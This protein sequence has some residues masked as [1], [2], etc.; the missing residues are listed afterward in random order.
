M[1]IDYIRWYQNPSLKSSTF[2]KENREEFPDSE[3]EVESSENET[4]WR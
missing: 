4:F 3:F 2:N 1:E